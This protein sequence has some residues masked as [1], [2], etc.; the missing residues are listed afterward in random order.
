MKK[1]R[2]GSKNERFKKFIGLTSQENKFKI[3]YEC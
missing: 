3:K 2:T 1:I